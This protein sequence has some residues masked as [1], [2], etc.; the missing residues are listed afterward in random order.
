[1]VAQRTNHHRRPAP[2]VIETKPQS[3]KETKHEAFRRL[4]IPR[5]QR[6]LRD[7]Q[8]LG[9]LANPVSYEW[10]EQDKQKIV[11]AI[12]HATLIVEAKLEGKTP[13]EEF[14]L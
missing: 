12:A 9:Q 7:L 11:E 3:Q 14:S 5:T 4:A 1:M 2:A 10:T 13:A 6:V 8:Y